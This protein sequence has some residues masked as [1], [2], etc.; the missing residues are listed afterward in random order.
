MALQNLY[1]KNTTAWKPKTRTIPPM[2]LAASKVFFFEGDD[3]GT[4]VVVVGPVEFDVVA[5]VMF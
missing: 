3:V 1:K 2:K 5:E 4:I